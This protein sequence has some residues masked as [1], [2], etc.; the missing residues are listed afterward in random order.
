MFFGI[1]NS[2]ATF[3]TIMNKILKDIINK[4]KVAAFVDDVLVGTETEK[5]HNKIVKEVLKRLEKNNL[6][7]KLE[8][9]IQ[10]VRKIKFLKIIIGPNRIEIEKKKVDEILSWPKPKNVKDIRKFLDLVNYY[11][12]FIKD[13]AQITRP[14][15]VLTKKDVKW[16][17][18][19]EQQQAFDELKKESL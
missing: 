13:F 18:E 11:K 2:P 15:N 19:R 10:K 17:Q 16:Q 12:R 4:G 9:C 7:I 8:K 3:Q 14:I 6:Y 1:T 5:E